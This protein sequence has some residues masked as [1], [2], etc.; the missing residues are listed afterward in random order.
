MLAHAR[1]LLTS[2]PQGATAYINADVREPGKIVAEAAETLDF[3]QPIALILNGI[4]G[5]LTD[6]GAA[7]SIVRQ[8]TGALPS[9]SYL[10]LSDGTSAIAG[11][12]AEAAQEGYNDTGALPYVLRTPQ[13]IAS[14]FDGLELVPPGVVSCPLWRPEDTPFGAP[15]EVD[16]FGGVA[17]KP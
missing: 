11:Q 10:L 1:A 3:S 13:E 9:G 2:T 4:L 8:L 14:F 5:H 17:R 6:L 7:R 16:L 15:A 12:P